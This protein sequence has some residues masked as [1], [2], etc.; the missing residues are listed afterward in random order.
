M[1]IDVEAARNV[2]R[3]ARQRVRVVGLAAL[4]LLAL[5]ALLP[6]S[7]VAQ[8]TPWPTPTP[9]LLSPPSLPVGGT[10]VRSTP[11]PPGAKV[12]TPGMVPQYEHLIRINIDGIAFM[13]HPDPCGASV[14]SAIQAHDNLF[15]GDQSCDALISQAR[16]IQRQKEAEDPTYANEPRIT[17]A[18][19]PAE[20]GNDQIHR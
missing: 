8:D 12:P 17:P 20:S 2:W 11:I 14:T 7:G 16:A 13:M 5:A 9:K 3:A 10:R 15:T 4:S 1:A 19:T 6:I 18:P